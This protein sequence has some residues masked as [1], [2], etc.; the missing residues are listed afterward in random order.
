MVT[1]LLP[2]S[3][4][5]TTSEVP[6]STGAAGAVPISSSPASRSEN[7]DDMFSDIPP[8]AGEVAGFGH[9]PILRATRAASRSTETGARN[10][11][12]V[13]LVNEGFIRAQHEVN[14]LKAQLD[15]QGGETEKFQFLLQEKEDQLS[16]AAVLPNLQFE[17]K[18]AKAENLRLKSK[19]ADMIE[20]NWLLEADNVDLGRD[21][22]NFTMRLGELEATI[23]Q[24]WSELDSVKA[25]AAKMAKRHHQLESESANDKE[26]LRVAEE[27]VETRARISDELKSKLEE[28][29]EANDLLQTEFESA[30]QIRIAL[31]EVRS[32]LDARLKKVEANLEKSLKDM[33]AVEARST[34]L[35]EYERW[36]SR[37]A[38]LEQVQR[39]LEDIQA[40]ILEAKE[41][42]DRAKK[43]LDVDS[44]DSEQMVS[45]NSSSNHTE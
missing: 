6:S 41:I 3:D 22:A 4:Q 14:D 5:A 35:I 31:L 44:E 32:E 27:K 2:G 9:L 15:A 29:T 38:T 33:E 25:E 18:M 37:R 17:L 8:V 21:N 12:S 40:R 19:L 13:V 30:N 24:L 28:A 23:S 36:K 26:K 7:L 11:L 10:T 39:G 43:S 20:K 45:D 1:I 16:Q 34:I 42:E